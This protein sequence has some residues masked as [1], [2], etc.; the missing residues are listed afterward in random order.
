[1]NPEL[2]PVAYFP[3][4]FNKTQQFWNTTLKGILCSLQMCSET[5]LSCLTVAQTA[6]YIVTKNPK[7][8]SLPQECL[9]M[10]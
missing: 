6:Y 5:S 7:P 1:M 10:F 8:L 3:G 2:I 4:T 9:V